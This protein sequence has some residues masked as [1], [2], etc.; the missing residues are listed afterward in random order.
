MKKIFAFALLMTFFFKA[1]AYRIEY[2]AN[3]VISRP[4]YEDL[5][6]A[7]GAITI[8]APVYGDLVCGGGNISINDS[9][10]NDI[11]VAGGNVTF[12]G[13]VN[14][15]IRC[16]GGQLYIQKSIGGDLVIAGG[17]VTVNKNV[18]IGGGLLITGGDIYFSGVVKNSI[19]AGAGKL[20]FGG[21]AENDADLRCGQ[22]EIDG[23][24]M[25][26]SVLAARVIKLGDSA[27]FHNDV[28]YWNKKGSLDFRN[29]VK[30]G[31]AVYDPAL[32]IE[33]GRW[34]YLGAFT[35][36]GLLW[37]IG[38]AFL[39][40]AIIQYLFSTT[41]QKAGNTVFYSTLKSLGVGFLF[42]IAVPVAAVIAFVTVIGVPAGLLLLFNYIIL[43]ILATVICSVVTANWI[44]NR[45][46]YKWKY[47]R[48]VFVALG[49]FIIF[50]LLSLTPF[51]GWLIMIIV[52][53]I[54]FGAILL[55]VRWKKQQPVVASAE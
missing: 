40:I 38:M 8:N 4:V 41:M 36:L 33:T 30:N 26:K 51:V 54:A 18:I 11:L 50:K 43:I 5:Y 24:I 13:Y 19:K 55:N 35:I 49:V 17:Q 2:G 42:F 25:G 21:V 37:Y 53:C 7:G 28:R 16:A 1:S 9:V 12:N 20:F 45:F 39:M 31:K 32:K 34:Y 3:V 29:T 15:D 22:M 46:N 44:N 47:W 10:M 23:T 6:I 52:A 27:A 14:D 48:L